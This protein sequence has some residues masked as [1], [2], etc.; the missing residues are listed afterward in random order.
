VAV[1]LLNQVEP[2]LIRQFVL[3]YFGVKALLKSERRVAPLLIVSI[4][5]VA[6]LTLKTIPSIMTSFL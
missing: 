3:L 5:F 1:A 6:N 2:F 4:I